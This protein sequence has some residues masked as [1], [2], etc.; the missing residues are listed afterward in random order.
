MYS[1]SDEEIRKV[2]ETYGFDYLQAR[3]HLIGRQLAQQ[4]A[5]RRAPRPEWG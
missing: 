1:P 2:M 4:H 3:N 5:A